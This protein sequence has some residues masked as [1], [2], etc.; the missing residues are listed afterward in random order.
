MCIYIYIHT[1]INTYIHTHK[2]IYTHSVYS[3][4]CVYVCICFFLRNKVHIAYYSGESKV[5]QYLVHSI[6]WCIYYITKEVKAMGGTECGSIMVIGV[7]IHCALLHSVCDLKATL[8]NMQPSLIWELIL[9]KIEL[10]HNAMKIT[11]C[12]CCRKR[13]KCSLSQ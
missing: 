5:L 4:V 6:L 11:K 1:H 8:I 12:I 10:V 13:W 7:F 3:F 2:R 9:Y